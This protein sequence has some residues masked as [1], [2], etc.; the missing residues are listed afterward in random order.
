MSQGL[1]KKLTL[2]EFV[3]L[4]GEQSPHFLEKYRVGLVK[5]PDQ[6]AE[7]Q[8]IWEWMNELGL[9]LDSEVE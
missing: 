2:E 1:D 7:P 4:L 5:D 6:F 8:M 9:Y 3:K